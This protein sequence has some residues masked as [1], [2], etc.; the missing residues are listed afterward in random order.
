MKSLFRRSILF[1]LR[2]RV[3]NLPL[4]IIGALALTS[5]RFDSNVALL[6]PATAQAQTSENSELAPIDP[7]EYQK[8][9]KRAHELG[10]GGRFNTIPPAAQPEYRKICE[11]IITASNAEENDFLDALF[12][13]CRNRGYSQQDVD[14]VTTLDAALRSRPDDW[15][16]K[17][18]AAHLHREISPGYVTETRG[19]VHYTTGSRKEI[20][21]TESLRLLNDALP[22][23]RAE[24]EKAQGSE[25]ENDLEAWT[26]RFYCEFIRALGYIEHDTTR[27]TF[28]IYLD[29]EKVFVHP[30]RTVDAY[31]KNRTLTDLSVLPEVEPLS[32]AFSGK[33]SP[34][35]KNKDELVFYKTPESYETAQNDG[36]RIQALRAELCRFVP[37]SRYDVLHARAREAHSIFGLQWLSVL[38]LEGGALPPEAFELQTLDDSETLMSFSSGI[39]RVTLP[40]D[41]NYIKLFLELTKTDRHVQEGVLSL[42]SEYLTRRRFDKATEILQNALAA[43]PEPNPDDA[44]DSPTN[45]FRSVL[46]KRLSQLVDPGVSFEIPQCTISDR[47]ASVAL[48]CRNT[49]AV[50]LEIQK[51][52]VDAALEAL[53]SP[54][55]GAANFYNIRTL[56]ESCFAAGKEPSQTSRPAASVAKPSMLVPGGLL[57]EIVKTI[58]TPIERAP[59]LFATVHTT[60]LPPLEPGAYL[61]KCSA[62]KDDG[63]P[64]SEQPQDYL[65]V[66]SSDV[67]ILRRQVEG[68]TRFFV[69][70]STS[71]API[72]SAD[73]Q[74]FF[75]NGKNE[76]GRQNKLETLT[77]QTDQNGSVFLP[78]PEPSSGSQ[79]AFV[80]VKT[81]NDDGSSALSVTEFSN[82]WYEK[83]QNANADAP[84]DAPAPNVSFIVDRPV[85]RPNQTV[86]YRFWI[87]LPGH[88]D[89]KEA[90]STA[91]QTAFCHIMSPSGVSV[92]NENASLDE[93]GSYGGAFTLPS[94]AVPG[95]YTI[96]FNAPLSNRRLNLP[97]GQFSV[98]QA[99]S[100][101][102]KGSID[103]D[104]DGLARGNKLKATFSAVDPS[105][106]PATSAVVSYSGELQRATLPQIEGRWDGLY[107]EGYQKT[108]YD[109]P[110]YPGWSQWGGE[111]LPSLGI[112]SAPQFDGMV[113]MSGGGDMFDSHLRNAPSMAKVILDGASVKNA[114]SGSGKLDQK[115]KLEVELTPSSDD[116]FSRAQKLALRAVFMFEPERPVVVNKNVLLSAK[117][118]LTD[119]QLDR[120][121]YQSGDTIVA[122]FQS[123]TSAGRPVQGKATVKLF[124][125]QYETSEDGAIKPTETE[126]ASANA[127]TDE[128]GLGQVRLASK[129]PGQY[130]VSCVVES[131]DGAQD[132][133]GTL[134]VVTDADGAVPGDRARFNALEIIPDKAVYKPGETA[135][136]LV[137]SNRSDASVYVFLR[138]VGL[139][140]TSEPILVRLENGLGRLD[141]PIAASDCP[142]I[143]LEA[144][145]VFDGKCYAEMRELFVPPVERALNVT[146]AQKEKRVRKGEPVTLRLR[147]TDAAGAPVACQVAIRAVEEESDVRAREL[148]YG[149]HARLF[150]PNRRFSWP[151]VYSNSDARVMGSYADAFAV[152]SSPEKVV[153]RLGPLGILGDKVDP[154]PAPIESFVM[155]T[156]SLLRYQRTPLPVGQIETTMRPTTAPPVVIQKL[157][158]AQLQD[159]RHADFVVWAD[160]LT[161]SDDG[162]VEFKFKA[163][164]KPSTLRVS[165]YAVGAARQS[166]V[167]ETFVKTEAK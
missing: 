70:D 158:S 129:E 50:R 9:V 52:R 43:I 36:E 37:S 24:N 28:Q 27:S 20:L 120:G 100:R 23:V 102:F 86:H 122:T 90:T 55:A 160:N 141:V 150:A 73:V 110:W 64:F 42:E 21:R 7:D 89:A 134:V 149:A 25:G 44:T 19:G 72:V 124:A 54:D 5:A 83:N 109:A 22:L 133:R 121:Y 63:A 165:V 3:L 12:W 26:I 15:R 16:L 81:K 95:V 40:D 131:S 45:S 75:Q 67:T 60:E 101:D 93:F 48:R 76:P 61:V 166:G 123:R 144:T 38:T 79:K 92:S 39:A 148:V 53:T 2:N 143:L 156:S 71:G 155:T 31:Y 99:K 142:N 41:Y 98:E 151:F 145:T 130:R 152:G 34:F 136:L 161:T 107:G 140:A 147:V 33:G 103:V 13:L 18:L 115:G 91:N 116:A 96:V 108:A 105:G 62:L 77:A 66:W 127:S 82:V 104:G 118:F 111:R 78:A 113:A 74:V 146:V 159:A 35:F 46:Q 58:D 132:E 30:Y 68:G 4:L 117:P 69:V 87:D 106:K 137:A 10:S 88:E 114:V 112:L 29:K 65:V 94:D 17:T 14:P 167:C 128:N 6:A 125:I 56:L 97:V 11:R 139:E 164:E 32:S 138:T 154:E 59:D 119:I 85:C 84:A 135:R 162:T 80:A 1:P 51:L 57:G 126:V 157:T 8:L 163:P 49:N 153:P 47:R